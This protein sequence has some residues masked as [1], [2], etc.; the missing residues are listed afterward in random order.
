ML[1]CESVWDGREC[2]LYFIMILLEHVLGKSTS[3]Y[4]YG[5]SS[6]QTTR[7]AEM[8]L[9]KPEMVHRTYKF[10]GGGHLCY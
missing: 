7:L 8:A 2:G 6:E 4:G 3:F 9:Q 1:A 5:R 10:G